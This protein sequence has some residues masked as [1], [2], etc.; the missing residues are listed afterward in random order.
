MRQIQPDLWEAATESPFPGLT[1]HAYLLRREQGNVLFYATANSDELAAMADLGGVA[2]HFLSHR[3][4]FGDSLAE[5]RERYG[6]QLGCHRLEQDDCARYCLPDR[7]FGERA[8]LLDDVEVI[9]TP[10]H[11]P[12]SVCFVAR[13]HGNRRYLFTGDTL[14]CAGPG[15]WRAGYIPGHST[16]DDALGMISSLAVIREL[17]PDLVI[18]SAFSGDTG[19]QA[20]AP[21]DWPGYVDEALAGLQAVL[22]AD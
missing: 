13:G 14:Y 12:G 21:G 3:D 17:A 18:S 15:R 16:R 7:L 20:M 19:Y 6:A 8:L 2:Y 22:D 11:S 1:T 5:V 10:G 4:E 9:P